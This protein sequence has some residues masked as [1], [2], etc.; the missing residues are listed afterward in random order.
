MEVWIYGVRPV[1]ELL[2]RRPHQVAEVWL[3]RQDQVQRRI[4]RQAEASGIRCRVCRP[5]EIAQR[6]QSS[7]HQGIAARAPLPEYLDWQGLLAKLRSAELSAESRKAQAVSLLVLDCIQ[8]PQNLGALLRVAEGV[9]ARAVVIPQDRAAGFSPAVL[10]ASAGA[11][12]WVPL[13]Q[14]KNLR[15]ALEELKHE[16]FWVVAADPGGERDFQ[17]VDY[18]ARTALVIGSEGEGIRPLVLRAC[19]QRVR[20][21][22]RGK[23]M[24]L[25]AAVA[26]GVV[27]FEVARQAQGRE[28][29][30]DQR[31]GPNPPA[32]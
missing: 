14:V 31:K 32:P 20:I 26:A 30:P 15:R 29:G 4:R 28:K 6:A 9:G 3:A 24:S 2:R 16:G 25:N 17:E 11:G 13:V 12:E 23:V 7:A 22:L 27:L 18:P 21:P 5:E 19:D 10:S 1:E 8:D